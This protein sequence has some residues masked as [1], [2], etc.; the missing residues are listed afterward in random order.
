MSTTAA[1][2]GLSPEQLATRK[3]YVTASEMA[4]VMG[5][6]Q[7]R[8]AG[9]V[10]AL[11][12][13]KV[14]GDESGDAAEWGHRLEPALL[15]WAAGKLET[16]ITRNVWKTSGVLGGTC[17]AVVDFDGSPLEAKTCGLMNFKALN[18]A[19]WGE[20]GTDEVPDRFLVQVHVQM[21]VTGSQYAHLAALLAGHGHRLYQ[22]KRNANLCEEIERQADV[23]WKCVQRDTPPAD[24][25][26]LEVVKRFRRVP[27]RVVT[28][29]DEVARVFIEANGERKRWE[30]AEEE[31]KAELLAAMRDADGSYVED[32][33]WSGG[34]IT[35]RQNKSSERFD[36]KRFREENP[37]VA[38]QF[39]VT[40]EGA[41]VLRVKAAAGGGK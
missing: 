4:A 35:Y 40:T 15:D 28:V 31:A 19:E 20:D 6:D 14:E 30:A 18:M 2:L 3:N 13:G 16:S 11:K 8:T 29:R 41:R 9:D 34:S 1:P 36:A 22:I 7:F 24:A 10:W 33:Q 26:S 27:G 39:M 21:I 32:A 17:D 37:K 5:L 38:A 12:T 25:P 23:F